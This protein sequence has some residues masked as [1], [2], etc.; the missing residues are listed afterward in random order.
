MYTFAPALPA[1]ELLLV[2]TCAVKDAVCAL[3]AD[4]D[5]DKAVGPTPVYEGMLFPCPECGTPITGLFVQFTQGR[6]RSIRKV[7]GLRPSGG[8]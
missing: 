1:L 4:F 3:A 5:P 8:G 6:K 2:E 7:A